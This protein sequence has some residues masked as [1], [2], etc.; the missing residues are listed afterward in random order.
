MPT[1]PDS[2]DPEQQLSGTPKLGVYISFLQVLPLVQGHLRTAQ[3]F[4]GNTPGPSSFK[5]ENER[6]LCI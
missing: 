3:E 6:L 2:A 1:K 4:L 5:K